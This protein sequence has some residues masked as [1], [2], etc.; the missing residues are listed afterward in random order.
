ML[1]K[2]QIID[3]HMKEF[4]AEPEVIVEVPGVLVLFG[5]FAD[6]FK[7]YALCGA[8]ELRLYV[9]ISKRPDS[10]VRISNS[11][12]N[13]HKRF[14]LSTSA[15]GIKFRKEDRWGN[16]VKGAIAETLSSGSLTGMNIALNGDL[17]ACDNETVA[18]AVG[19][20]ITMAIDR[21]YDLNMDKNV[22][23][24]NIFHS[25]TVF[26]SENCKYMTLL[27]MLN[28]KPGKLLAY[29]M[30]KIDYSYVGFPFVEGMERM[31][32]VESK[33][34]QSAMREEVENSQASMK[35]AVDKLR[36]YYARGSLREFPEN[37]LKD[38]IVPID[39]ESRQICLFLL[40]ESKVS[41]EAPKLFETADALHIGRSLSRIEKGLR[42][43]LELTCP[44]VDWL[45]KRAGENPSCLGSCM[46][47]TGNSGSIL[48][49]F[50]KE[51][52]GSF[53]E[54]LEEYEHIFGF[55]AKWSYYTPG[56]GA[57]VMHFLPSEC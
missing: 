21:L 44:E 37:E 33:I 1:E 15:S 49:M 36:K 41:K 4:E 2:Q 25:C 47:S 3:K 6:H 11:F 20:G 57:C 30:Q 34:P 31:L 14:S 51:G 54:K 39:E 9:S 23:I 53:R 50:G 17:L 43:N 38:R 32:V 27:T 7:G 45:I 52:I 24:R 48:M 26:C 18:S 5:Q 10:M 19:L 35:T 56:C 8:N 29:D 12:S 28:A 22:I 46:V 13:D 16:Y 40:D 42:D 55:K